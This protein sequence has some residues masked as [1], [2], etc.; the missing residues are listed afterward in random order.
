M[1]LEDMHRAFK[2]G[3]RTTRGGFIKHRILRCVY[4]SHLHLFSPIPHFDFDPRFVI[5]IN[6][7]GPRWHRIRMKSTRASPV[8][9]TVLRPTCLFAGMTDSRR[10][11]YHDAVL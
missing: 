4:H 5:K 9:L 7:D 10:E 6:T 2:T 11:L 8:C 3:Q 1:H